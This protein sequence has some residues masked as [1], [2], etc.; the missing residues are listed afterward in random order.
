MKMPFP[1]NYPEM[2]VKKSGGLTASENKLAILGY[3]TFLSLWSYP[4]PYK[5]QSNGK[6]LCDLLIVFDKHIII[7]SDKDCAYGN[8]GDALVD[9]RRWYKKAIQKSAEQLIGAKNWILHYPDRIAVDAKCSQKLPLEIKITPETRFHLI[10]IAHGAE[11]SCKAYFSGED[12][13]L[14]IDNQIVGDMHIGKDC[15]P[16]RIGQ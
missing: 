15:D 13:G 11:E 7:F 16:F 12:G 1:I 8:S 9:W 3:H 6:E 5:M 4:N 2:V 14:L 10:A